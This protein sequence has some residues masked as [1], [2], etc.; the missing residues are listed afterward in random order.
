MTTGNDPVRYAAVWTAVTAW[1]RE[2]Q[3]LLV[4]ELTAHLAGTA[5]GPAASDPAPDILTAFIA[6]ILAGDWDR[7]AGR[8]RFLALSPGRSA[9]P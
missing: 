6:R 3:Q 8:R 2:D 5:A 7:E 4:H 1:A 9:T